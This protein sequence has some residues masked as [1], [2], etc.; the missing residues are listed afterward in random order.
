MAYNSNHCVLSKAESDN[1]RGISLE[2]TVSFPVLWC[3]LHP[4]V[5]ALDNFFVKYFDIFEVQSDIIFF[6]LEM[7]CQL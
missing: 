6:P 5:I 7:E 3:F 1:N 2:E 4:V